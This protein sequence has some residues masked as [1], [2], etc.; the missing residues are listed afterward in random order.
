MGGLP[1]L[2]RYLY[3]DFKRPNPLVLGEEPPPEVSDSSFLPSPHSKDMPAKP[4]IDLYCTGDGQEKKLLA[5][6]SFGHVLVWP[7]LGVIVDTGV[8]QLE[9]WFSQ[10]P[11]T[12][13]LMMVH[14]QLHR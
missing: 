11:D 9:L 7:A 12:A 2:P 6:C 14:A 8:K 13:L 10:T 1:P 4:S 3:L 5:M